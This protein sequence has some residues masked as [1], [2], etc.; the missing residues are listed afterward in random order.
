M[1]ILNKHEFPEIKYNLKV[2][3]IQKKLY[4]AVKRKE[5]LKFVYYY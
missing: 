3:N 5:E 4:L 2:L 1:Q